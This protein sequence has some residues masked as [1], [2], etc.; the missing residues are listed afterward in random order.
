MEGGV[1]V[2]CRRL[3]L[4]VATRFGFRWHV[5]RGSLYDCAQVLCFV[6][7]GSSSFHISK[8]I[9]LY[10]IVTLY[11]GV[12]N[13]VYKCMDGLKLAAGGGPSALNKLK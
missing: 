5:A 10:G 11:M 7:V 4:P 2:T 6:Q 8:T 1:V 3:R 9:H 13:G 12:F